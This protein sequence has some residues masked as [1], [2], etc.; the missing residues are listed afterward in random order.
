MLAISSTSPIQ[1][2]E[3][4]EIF[5]KFWDHLTH[6]LIILYINPLIFKTIAKDFISSLGFPLYFISHWLYWHGLK[7]FPYNCITSRINRKKKP[8]P[9]KKK[10]NK[11]FFTAPIEVRV[12]KF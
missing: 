10:G 6:T 11:T 9:L 2:V 7:I 8:Q 12:L 5:A 4:K 3:N 1:Q